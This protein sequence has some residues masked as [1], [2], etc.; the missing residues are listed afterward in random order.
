MPDDPK[1]TEYYRCEPRWFPIARSFRIVEIVEIV[2]SDRQAAPAI[3]IDLHIELGPIDRTDTATLRLTFFD[4]RQLKLQQPQLSHWPVGP[5]FI[6]S[7]RDRQWEG[8]NYGVSDSENESLS[9]ICRD[10]EVMLSD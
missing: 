2:E 9:F 1:I 7:I 6:T 10:F 5:L 3:R 4:V 8:A